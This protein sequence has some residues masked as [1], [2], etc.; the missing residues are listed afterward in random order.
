MTALLPSASVKKT[1]DAVLIL[2]YVTIVYEY[3]LKVNQ[4]FQVL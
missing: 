1:M 2:H 4:Y 3:L